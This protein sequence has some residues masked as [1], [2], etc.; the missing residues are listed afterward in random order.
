MRAKVWKARITSPLFNCKTYARNMEVLYRKM[1]EKYV[2]G[3]EP[4]HIVDTSKFRKTS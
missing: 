2:N 1:W 4:S 3:Q